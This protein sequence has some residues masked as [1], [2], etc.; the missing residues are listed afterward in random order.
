MD[1]EQVIIQVQAMAASCTDMALKSRYKQKQG[2][3][4]VS[5][6]A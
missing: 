3:S 2:A 1:H 6:V 5:G 4:S